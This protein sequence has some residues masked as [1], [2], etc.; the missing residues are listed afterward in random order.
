MDYQNFVGIFEK[1]GLFYGFQNCS[2]LGGIELVEEEE[3]EEEGAVEEEEEEEEE[4]EGEEGE[5]ASEGD[6]ADA[7]APTTRGIKAPKGKS[8]F[9]KIASLFSC[10]DPP[11]PAEV[12]DDEYMVDVI[13]EEEEDEE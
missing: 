13:P 2:C 11:L 9:S 10:S 4:E 8:L 5:A 6:A 12:E 1:S 7:P 3:E